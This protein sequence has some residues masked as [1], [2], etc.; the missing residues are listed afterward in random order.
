MIVRLYGPLVATTGGV[1][2]K[3]FTFNVTVGTAD[4]TLTPVN[5]VLLLSLYSPSTFVSSAIAQ[6]NAAPN[7]APAGIVTDVFAALEPPLPS[8][9]VRLPM[10]VSAVVQTL[11]VDRYSPSRKLPVAA[12][13]LFTTVFDTLN[14]WPGLR[15]RAPT[16]P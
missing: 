13:P 6:M 15:R 8:D 12:L 4:R 5:R 16:A 9:T 10:S 11:S 2:C 7:V 1:G 14:V 3:P